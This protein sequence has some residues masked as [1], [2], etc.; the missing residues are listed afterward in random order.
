MVRLAGI[1]RGDT[2]V[3]IGAGQGDLTR[4][5]AEKAG[6]VY[7]V[8]VDGDCIHHLQDYAFQYANISVVH[9]DFLDVSLPR[10][11][12]GKRIVVMGNIPYKI[13]GPILF[14][15]LEARDIVARAY[16]TMQ[17]EVAHRIVSKPFARTYGAL[18]VV[19]QVLCHVKILF[20]IKASVFVPPPK[21]DSAYLSFIPKEEKTNLP[22]EFLKLVRIC[23]QNKRKYLRYALSKAFSEEIIRALYDRMGFSDKVRAEEI[24]PD[25]FETIYLFLRN[26]GCL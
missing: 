20:T 10:L 21:V 15:L 9:D 13:T 8:E 25:Q 16:L 24:A 7:A 22:L 12:D 14:R 23:F 17:A 18:S 3:E 6:H 2:V 1:E 4:S 19:C 5:I 26:K 11:S